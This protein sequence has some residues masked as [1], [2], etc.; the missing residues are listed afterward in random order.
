M[1]VTSRGMA[2]TYSYYTARFKVLVGHFITALLNSGNPELQVYGQ[3]LST[4]K[5]GLHSMRHFFTV[6]LVLRL[7]STRAVTYLSL[8]PLLVKLAK[9][10]RTLLGLLAASPT[11]S[12]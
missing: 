10:I 3:V 1:F 4:K 7:Q 6:Q 8:V 2:M 11:P 5:L 12:Q 9:L